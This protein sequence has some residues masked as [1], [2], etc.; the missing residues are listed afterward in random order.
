MVLTRFQLISSSVLDLEFIL[1][2]SL[3]LPF[4]FFSSS[5]DS[6]IGVGVVLFICFMFLFSFFCSVFS[7]VAVVDVDVDNGIKV[8]DMNAGG[9]RGESGGLP[10]AVATREFIILQKYRRQCCVFIMKG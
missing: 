8:E 3:L 2:V 1:G 4:D 6:F 7:I 5:L 10:M 9:A